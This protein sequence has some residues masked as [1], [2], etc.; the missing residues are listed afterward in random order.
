[1][2]QEI[3]RDTTKE[4]N[5][6][7]RKVMPVVHLGHTKVDT[8]GFY[9]DDSDVPNYIVVN[10][11][12]DTLSINKS[13][14]LQDYA[15]NEVARP[16]FSFITAMKRIEQIKPCDNILLQKGDTKSAAQIISQVGTI[17]PQAPSKSFPMDVAFANAV[18]CFM[19]PFSI[20]IAIKALLKLESTAYRIY[21]LWIRN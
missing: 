2:L 20:I 15:V 4:V 13:N 7:G 21:N 17:E 10:Q 1:M 9:L 19:I 18:I 14:Y 11:F 5:F 8:I 6:R 16:D 3:R 12:G